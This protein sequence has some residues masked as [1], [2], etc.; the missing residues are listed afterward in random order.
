MTIDDP[1]DPILEEVDDDLDLEG[2]EE[3]E[4]GEEAAPEGEQSL[5]PGAP[6][7]EATP[8]SEPRVQTR[9]ERRIQKL[10]NR[11]KAA[12]AEAAQYRQYLLEMQRQQ[13]SPSR[14]EPTQPQGVDPQQELQMV[15]Q[16]GEA[17]RLQY[18]LQRGQQET[19]AVTRRLELQMAVNKDA[20][21]YAAHVASDPEFYGQY[22]PQVET[23]FQD[24]LR[25]GAPIDRVRIES[26]LIGEKVKKDREDA[27]KKARKAGAQRIAAQRTKPGSGRGTV[28]AAGP[29]SSESASETLR[30]RLENREYS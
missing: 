6:I 30:R 14:Q 1:K 7:P 8:Q 23:V 10:A 3:V 28:T 17:E 9:G 21:D 13:L 20:S 29:R 5:E 18:F 4:G 22:Q 16:M 2:E 12:E 19:Q 24:T 25:R 11:A 15:A 27:L 26:F